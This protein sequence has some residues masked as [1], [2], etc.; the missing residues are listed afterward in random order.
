MRILQTQQPSTPPYSLHAVNVRTHLRRLD[1]WLRR[2]LPE[3]MHL[4][5]SLFRQRNH[6][7]G[8]I[9][10]DYK[11]S[12]LYGA[13]RNL[14][15]STS[16]HVVK[17]LYLDETTLNS[18]L[19]KVLFRWAL[20]GCDCFVTN[21]TAEMPAYSAFLGL[22][23][24]RFHFLSWPSN[25]PVQA[26]VADDGYIFAAGRS[27]R[28]WNVLCE[29]ARRLPAPFVVVAERA[30]A[31]GMARLN[32]VT[33]YCDIDRQQYLDLLR[34]A[35]IVVVPLRPTVRSIGQAV[36][37]E[38][39]AFGKPIVAG[40]VPGIVDYV[41]EGETGLYYEPG[42]PG[43]LVDRL[44][45]LLADV[46]LRQCLGAQARHAVRDRFNKAQYSRA[47][48]DLMCQVAA[49]RVETRTLAQQGLTRDAGD[50]STPA[51]SGDSTGVR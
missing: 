22:P 7:D 19:R 25:L 46:A 23:E 28:D 15:G 34:K 51:I 33:T 21:C 37:L 36:V 38:A 9:T 49:R 35:R 24:D 4:A 20:K 16:F 8:V 18:R 44:K 32:N 27:F 10:S 26:D 30:A 6:Y 42:D 47:M 31:S 11:T 2:L 3:S 1:R 40:R 50:L 12:F 14:F 17:E 43:S 29:A 45:Q 13:L 48:L 5:F 39:M 41:C